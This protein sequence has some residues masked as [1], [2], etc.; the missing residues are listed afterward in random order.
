MRWSPRS[1]LAV[2]GSAAALAGAMTALPLLAGEPARPQVR[3][4]SFLASPRPHTQA[5]ATMPNQSAT[6][7]ALVMARA[8]AP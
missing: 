6:V 2:L 7:V 5:R 4:V 3:A 1:R 8:A